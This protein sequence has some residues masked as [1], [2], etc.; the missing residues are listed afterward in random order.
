VSH[1]IRDVQLH[2]GIA[3]LSTEV[4]LESERQLVPEF[5]FVIVIG[6]HQ[7]REQGI[8]REEREGYVVEL[9]ITHLVGKGFPEG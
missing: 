2:Q 7:Q 9:P 4:L 5:L 6:S 8:V 3:D 1:L